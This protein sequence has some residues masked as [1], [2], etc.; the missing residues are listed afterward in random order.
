MKPEIFICS[1][2]KPIDD[3]I[4]RYML[5]FS[6]SA[7]QNKIAK[8]KSRYNA[9]CMLA[10]HILAKT[11]IKNVFGIPFENQH[12]AYTARGKPYIENYPDVH[13]NISH[14]GDYVVCAVHDKPVGADIQ[15][16]CG[17][18][19]RTAERVCCKPEIL[20]IEKSFDKAH[21]FTKLWTQKEAVIKMY[22]N[23]I[24]NSD[25]KNCLTRNDSQVHIHTRTCGDYVLSICT[26]YGGEL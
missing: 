18:K 17:Y 24:A 11:A 8:Q 14:S 19:P 5:S 1:I 22:G 20:Q 13:F 7:R 15:K 2:K 4:F 10:G 9:D 23:S 25:I 21:E 6:D 12:F 16:I 3:G 26:Y